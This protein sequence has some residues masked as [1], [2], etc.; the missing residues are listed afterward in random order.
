MVLIGI[1]TPCSSVFHR[2]FLLTILCPFNVRN[3]SVEPSGFQCT[4]CKTSQLSV[5]V[6]PMK[7]GPLRMI[8]RWQPSPSCASKSTISSARFV[9]A[10]PTVIHFLLLLV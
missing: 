9:E 7:R 3:E 1:H 10:V 4:Q 2:A 6:F 8:S 5:H